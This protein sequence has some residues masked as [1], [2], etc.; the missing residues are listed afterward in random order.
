MANFAGSR[1]QGEEQIYSYRDNVT[2]FN[3]TK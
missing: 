1:K 2:G 3:E